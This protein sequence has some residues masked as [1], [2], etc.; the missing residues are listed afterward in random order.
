MPGRTREEARATLKA[1]NFQ[2]TPPRGRPH[3]DE[4]AAIDVVDDRWFDKSR[5]R[6]QA[7]VVSVDPLTSTGTFRVRLEVADGDPFEFDPGQ[8]V[9]IEAEFP[10]R[11]FRRIP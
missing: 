2:G 10:G 5:Y 11:G 1:G 9:G 4:L 7:R 6:R 8:F 3:S